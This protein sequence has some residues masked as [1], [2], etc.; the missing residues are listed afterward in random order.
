MSNDLNDVFNDEILEDEV[1]STEETEQQ[2]TDSQEESKEPT[3]SKSDE[4]VEEPKE[5]EGE[6]QE[7]DEPPASTDDKDTKSE[8]EESWT[9]TAVLDERRKRQDLEKKIQELEAKVNQPAPEQK[10]E[11][12]IIPD[13]IDDPVGYKNYVKDSLKQEMFL[14]RVNETKA[15]MQ[16]KHEDYPEMEKK[17]IE[18]SNDNPALAQKLKQASNPAKFAYDTAKKHLD[19]QKYSDP[20]YLANLKEEMKKEILA[21]LVKNQKTN[22]K[23]APNVD[24]PD[25]SNRTSV[26]SNVT[27]K[28]VFK[29]D[30]NEFF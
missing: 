22:S 8:P 18:L 19:S 16:A 3:D 24:I 12:E 9:R 29:G 17:F 7:S 25:L 26:E 28:E 10:Q 30:V 5:L 4:E 15:E 6:N 14:E 1:E 21:D 23:P 27:Q 2:E 11:E 20:N 13:P